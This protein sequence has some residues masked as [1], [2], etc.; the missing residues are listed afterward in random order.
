MFIK[1]LLWAEHHPR[2]FGNHQGSEHTIHT[3]KKP[4]TH[5]AGEAGKLDLSVLY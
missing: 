1:Y 5:L 4:A 2:V 3:L